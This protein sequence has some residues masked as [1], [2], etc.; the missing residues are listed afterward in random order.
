M[1]GEKNYS[2]FLVA[3]VSLLAVGGVLFSPVHAAPGTA[4][5][6]VIPLVGFNI[7][8][9]AIH[10]TGATL[11]WNTNDDT[12]STVEYGL[13]IGYGSVRTN[14][15]MV[16]YHTITLDGLSPGTTYHYRIVSTDASGEKYTSAD[17]QFTTTGTGPGPGGGGVG[18]GG[19]GGW[20]GGILPGL[21]APY[22]CVISEVT[23]VGLLKSGAVSSSVNGMA[24]VRASW[25][26]N[27]IERPTGGAR[28]TTCIRSQPGDS[29]RSAFDAALASQG[30][31]IIALAYVMEVVE[32]RPVATGT[33][34]IQ[35]DVDR[36]WVRQNGGPGAV[37]IISLG[38]DGLVHI[39]ET[40]FSNY[41]LDTGH[42][43]F[44]AISHDDLS[45]YALIALKAASVTVP[46]TMTTI[47]PTALPTGPP[48]IPTPGPTGLFAMVVILAIAIT[49][50][51]GL[52][53]HGRKKK[54]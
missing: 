23:G 49:L 38:D 28:F 47:A 43:N 7:S 14:S 39:L 1:R 3:C 51:I 41:V 22:S 53:L 46:T 15:T 2:V 24:D 29:A 44:R 36:S 40:K 4:I 27:I 32:S 21:P 34:T 12:N 17:F 6:G 35:M 26:A 11:T 30:L 48:P 9:S 16:T 45:L 18:G 19:G 8:V 52:I 31:Q 50:V 37:R 20:S 54:E 13:T 5:T 10:D 42:M 25:S 33:E